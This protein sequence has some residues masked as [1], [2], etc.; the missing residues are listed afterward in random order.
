MLAV[1]SSDSLPTQTHPPNPACPTSETATA[2]E[3]SLRV[4]P[5][6]NPI[7]IVRHGVDSSP[8]D[9]RSSIPLPPTNTVDD[10]TAGNRMS[11]REYV[12]DSSDVTITPLRSDKWDNVPSHDDT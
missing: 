10:T 7:E 2:S 11:M 6:S 4:N 3:G 1:I 8:Q 12:F 5:T 9:A